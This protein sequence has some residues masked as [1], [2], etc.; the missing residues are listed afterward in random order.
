LDRYSGNDLTRWAS[1]RLE[2]ATMY[3]QLHIIDIE[4]FAPPIRE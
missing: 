2:N 3:D 4:G 1:W